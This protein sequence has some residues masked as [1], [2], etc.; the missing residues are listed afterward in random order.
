MAYR[1]TEEAGK[2][3]KKQRPARFSRRCFCTGFLIIFIFVGI[4]SLMVVIPVVQHVRQSLAANNGVLVRDPK[5]AGGP[6][7]GPV[8]PKKKLV[9]IDPDTPSDV[10]FITSY[11]RKEE[12]ELVY[13]DEF[14]EEGRKFHPGD[15]PAWE[16]MD[17]WYEATG[18]EEYYDP[19]YITT[20]D[21]NLV[22]KVEDI[23]NGKLKYTS[24]MLQ[25]WN[26]VCFTGGRIEVRVSL[27]GDPR[28][29]GF[30]PGAWL[31]GNL[32][33]A[34]FKSTTDGLWP[35]S[36]DACDSGV[37]ANQS[38]TNN[39]SHLPG[40][41]LNKCVCPGEDHPNPGTGRGAPEIDLIEAL[42]N[43]A[44]GEVSQ[45]YQIAPFDADRK[46]RPKY[47]IYNSAIT[48]I[49][50]YTGSELQQAVSALTKLPTTIYEGRNYATFAVEYQPGTDGYITWFV[51]DKPT[52]TLDAD[53][54]DAN[55]ASKVSR[56]LIP[57]EPMYMIFN[58]AMSSKF[59]PISEN[60]KFP[61]HY[62]IDHVR[63]YQHPDRK[64][65]TC[66]PEDYPTS[67]YIDTHRK[68]YYN[69]NWT[70]WELAGYSAPKYSIDNKC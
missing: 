27:P 60:L 62:L 56:R 13:S 44:G 33:R 51:D 68:A 32:G 36:Y 8:T 31:L 65:V 43:H 40:Q 12:W 26:K 66:D 54:L 70:N 57:E 34:G 47:Q 25:S 58:L 3:V 63:I 5:S 24:G 41:R 4:I 55:K 18:D 69:K 11:L 28:V 35:Y 45:S 38:L 37:Q 22:I 20:K 61:N 23:P 42:T 19:D 67:N 50:S 48:S 10:K 1:E 7:L 64:S 29:S 53:A 30:W 2:Q 52:W 21:G 39:L 9:L 17:F 14:N 15:D 16:A 46:A 49:N 59:S 6:N